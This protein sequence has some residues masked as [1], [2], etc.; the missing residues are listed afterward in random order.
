MKLRKLEL[1]DAP[2]MLEW[3]HDESVVKSLH[4][5]FAAFTLAN[6]ENFIIAAQETTKE[7]H[8]AITDNEDVYMGTVSL[9]HITKENAEFAIAVRRSA[10]GKGYA[11][12]GMKEIIRIG[13]SEIGLKKIYWC[14]NETNVRAIKFY[15]KNKY[16]RVDINNC[17]VM[18]EVRGL[19]GYTED[20]I[21]KYIWY[22]ING[23]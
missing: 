5:N 21:Q 23:E 9:K 6:C 13:L 14:V 11:I 3:M 10:M 19:G 4:T 17:N 22:L 15:A 1:K 12:A 8:L 16:Q 7:L 2:L 18:K 20:Q